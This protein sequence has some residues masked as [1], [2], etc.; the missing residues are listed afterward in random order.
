[1]F[2]VG[3]SQ[4]SFSKMPNP[5]RIPQHVKQIILPAKNM[6]VVDFLDFKLPL[7]AFP[8]KFVKAEDYFSTDL[9]MTDDM[10]EIHSLPS[11]PVA[12]VQLLSQSLSSSNPT[13]VCCPHLRAMAGK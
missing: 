2:T 11:L 7:V 9:V 8:T 6:S 10:E 12:M 13:S 3:L 1:M 4:L 5:S